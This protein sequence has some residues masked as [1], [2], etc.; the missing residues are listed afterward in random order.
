MSLCSDLQRKSLNCFPEQPCGPG[1][2][3]QSPHQLPDAQHEMKP[4]SEPFTVCVQMGMEMAAWEAQQSM[5]RRCS[6]EQRRSNSIGGALCSVQGA[7]RVC[8]VMC[9][10][11]L[12]RR[13]AVWCFRCI[14]TGGG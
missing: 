11:Y 9:M 14:K 1:I 5:Q 4:A 10:L 13:C 7:R 3:Y 12:H 6:L 2:S 8:C